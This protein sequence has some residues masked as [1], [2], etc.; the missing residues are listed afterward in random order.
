MI[1][2]AGPSGSV[3]AATALGTTQ[4]LV[5]VDALQEFRVQS[6]S[7]SAEYGRNPGGQFAFET[8]SGTN[9]WHGSAFEYLRNG[10][11]DAQDWFSNYFGLR[12]PA[13]RQ[14]DFGGTLG[15]P[16]YLPRFGEG[17]PSVY[18]GKNKAFFFFSYEGLRLVA[19]QAATVTFVPDAALR[20][21][22]PAALQRVLNAFP[23]QSPNGIDDTAN[24]VAQFI[25]SWSNPSSIN[26]T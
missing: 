25:G 9:Q 22:A 18:N 13:L 7:Y 19:P 21:S 8:K 15:G 10:A 6:S 5:S 20:A 11:L 16:L 24:G 4:A 14:N 23:L 3:P 1:I 17:G 26:S 2:G 12:Q